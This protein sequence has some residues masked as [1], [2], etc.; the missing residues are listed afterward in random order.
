MKKQKS[1][2]PA[3]TNLSLL[4]KEVI[5][6]QKR[7]KTG[8]LKKM[9][10]KEV[11]FLGFLSLSQ[12]LSDIRKDFGKFEKDLTSESP[13]FRRTFWSFRNAIWAL[14]LSIMALFLTIFAVLMLKIFKVI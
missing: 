10:D 4:Q 1:N 13:T 12:N 2:L 6:M 3:K 11:M 8:G 14:T 5:D 9:T 7:L